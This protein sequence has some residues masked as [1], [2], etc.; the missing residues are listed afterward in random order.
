M[1]GVCTFTT[2]ILLFLIFIG[3]VTK[4]FLQEDVTLLQIN[5]LFIYRQ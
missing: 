5:Y 2:C 1:L 4:H 3:V